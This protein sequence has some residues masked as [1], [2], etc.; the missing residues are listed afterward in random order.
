MV[1][2][3]PDDPVRPVNSPKAVYQMEPGALDLFRTF[4]SGAWEAKLKGYL[5]GR[6]TLAA[7]YARARKQTLVSVAL[8][9]DKTILLSPG[10]HSGLIKGV[11]EEFAPR[12][13]PGAVLVYAGDTG[14]K[15]AY[16]DGERLLGLGVALDS[17]GKM[18][19]VVLHDTERNWL[20]LVEAVTSRGPVDPKRH[21]ELQRLFS[22]ALA[23]LVYVTAFPDRAVLARWLGEIA[24]E[25][26]VWIAE[27][28]SHLIHFD[29]ESFLGPHP[30]R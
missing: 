1:L 30:G 27:D 18:P 9:A 13:A 10:G 19:D 26:E 21:G 7:K 5:S 2:Y 16:F 6:A 3:N 17:H 29:G 25:T 8:G 12:F 20:F 11:I 28:P 14:G 23:G 24:W 4:G 15:W 22:G